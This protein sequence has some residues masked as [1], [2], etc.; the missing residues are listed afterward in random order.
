MMKLQDSLQAGHSPPPERPTI[1][2]VDDSL[3]DRRLAGRLLEHEGEWQVLYAE[4][5]AE[6]LDL[7]TRTPA[8]TAVLT[9]LQMPVM[10]GL[11]LVEEIRSHY[12]QVPVILMT[13]QGSE[14]IA[15]VA[16]KAGAASYVSKRR[17]ATDLVPAVTQVLNALRND[18]G[19]RRV[20]GCLAVRTA[21]FELESDPALVSP[22][23]AL[24][25][26]DMLAIGLCDE[27]GAMRAGIALEEALLNAV[28]HGNL[29]I[30]SDLKKDNDDAF[31]AQA[32]QRRCEEPYRSRRTQVVARLTPNEAVFVI[33]DQGPGFDITKLPDPEDPEVLLRPCGRGL[34]LMRM[35]MDEVH[36]NENGNSVTMIMRRP[37]PEN[38]L[39]N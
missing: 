19:R 9:D 31:H 1:L 10:D 20:L 4:N 5:G 36:Y 17:Q 14:E 22:L 33:T 6:A 27:N 8:P 34:M 3:I 32:T 35:F 15:V 37:T 12:P 39:S 21:Q 11:A 30:S 18:A 16:L 28:Y 29:E 2:V 13:G 23:V 7:L 26:D 25:R 24:L 38:A